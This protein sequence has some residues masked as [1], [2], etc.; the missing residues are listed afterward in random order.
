MGKQALSMWHNRLGKTTFD[1]WEDVGVRYEPGAIVR[2][3]RHPVEPLSQPEECRLVSICW[4]MHGHPC[5]ACRP[6]KVR[7]PQGDF[8]VLPLK[9]E[10]V[11]IIIIIIII[12]SNATHVKRCRAG[13]DAKHMLLQMTLELEGSNELLQKF[14][15]RWR[16]GGSRIRAK[17]VEVRE[18]V[19]HGHLLRVRQLECGRVSR[20]RRTERP[21]RWP[22]ASTT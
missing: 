8:A 9:R 20:C 21:Y 12:I 19:A 16:V 18:E 14:G 17:L 3:E 11:I 15:G 4:P 13:G 22:A 6:D 2:L 7:E 10:S 1:T 5:V